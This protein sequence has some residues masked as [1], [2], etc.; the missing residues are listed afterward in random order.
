MTVY[1]KTNPIGLD[2]KLLR[3]QE[4]IDLIGWTD[5][6]VYGRLYIDE[7]NSVKVP[8]T[9]VGSGEY[10]EVL[11]DDRKTAVFGFFVGDTR[12]GLSMISVPVQL[13]CTCNLDKIFNSTERKDEEAIMQVLKIIKRNTMIVH[14]QGIQTGFSNVFSQLSLDRYKFRD[15]H[16]WLNFSIGFDIVYRNEI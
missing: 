12:S 3:L 4:K 15:S 16:P 14:E 6:D 11:I 10:K 8:K 2:R 7:V 9:H 1:S 5:I 13:V